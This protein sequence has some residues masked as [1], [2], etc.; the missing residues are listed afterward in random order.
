[1]NESGD[2]QQALQQALQSH[3]AGNLGQAEKIYRRILAAVPGQADALHYLGVIGLQTGRFDD[4][5]KLIGQALEQRPDDLDALTNLGNALQAQG[6]FDEAV[7]RYRHALG[8]QPRNAMIIANLGNALLQSGQPLAAISQYESALEIEP[9]LVDTRRKLADALLGQGRPGEALGHIR[10]ADAAVQDSP[11]IQVS[12]GNILAEQ[13][14][15]DEAI[16]CF[17]KVLAV[18]P[19]FAPVHCNIANVLRQNGLLAE[20]IERYEQALQLAPDYCE[21]HYDLGIALQDVG[22]K[23]KAMVELRKAIAIDAHCAKAWRAIAGLVKNSLT[24]DDFGTMKAAL[25]APGATADE[26]MDLNF[27]LGKGYEDAADYAAAIDHFHRGNRLRRNAID[28]SIE[29]DKKAFDDLKST[30]DSGFFERWSGAGHEDATPVFIVGMPRSGTTLTE[31]ILASHSQV[32]GGGEL[33]YLARA[34]AERFPMRDGIDYTGSLA[35]AT[36]EDFAAIASSYLAAIRELDAD[37][38]HITDKLPNNFLNVGIIRIVFPNARIIHCVRDPRDTCYSIYKHFFSARG[39]YYAYDMVELGR[40]Y[41]LYADLMRHWN[42]TLPGVMYE[43]CYEDMVRE[44]EQTTRALLEACGLP[45]EPACMEFHKTRRPVATI[46]ASQ[47]R[48]PMYQGSVGAWQN[49]AESLQPLLDIL[50][51]QTSQ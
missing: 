5:V 20:A 10:V 48:Q 33:R 41:K 25:R 30:F 27:A 21:G 32:H 15:I 38:C 18:K 35:E 4:A 19:D 13:G 40:Y 36:N 11:E 3:G 46:S 7:S 22:E 43:L 37:A 1:M 45:W 34:I 39:H 2:I 23:D 6:R 24:E 49:V 17:E 42:D 31:Q 29:Q 14:R 8:L 16:A 26:R 44:Q 12:M 47:V 28:Y 50:D 51:E 9:R